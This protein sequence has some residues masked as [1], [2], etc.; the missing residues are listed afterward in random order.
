[1][2]VAGRFCHRHSPTVWCRSRTL[3][4]RWIDDKHN[5][6]PTRCS[7]LRIFTEFPF[8]FIVVITNSKHSL[9]SLCHVSSSSPIWVNFFLVVFPFNHF[10]HI[11]RALGGGITGF[12]SLNVFPVESVICLR[13]INWR[14]GR[15]TL[16][17][18]TNVHTQDTSRRSEKCFLAKI[19]Q[20][21]YFDYLHFASFPSNINTI[22]RQF[23]SI[24]D[25]VE[26]LVLGKVRIVV[27][28][29]KESFG[30][31]E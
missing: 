24:Y 23:L 5:H 22:C 12:I 2:N 16:I 17:S 26:G 10:T 9:W 15:V 31:F 1:M 20:N 27:Y 6:R 7:H 11:C 29:V 19:K 25:E 28:S 18:E 3:K 4:L 30:K 8:S 21:V 13:G 14:S